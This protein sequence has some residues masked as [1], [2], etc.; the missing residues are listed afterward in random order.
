MRA[1]GID[2]GT[3]NSVVAV[4]ENDVPRIVPN[5]ENLPLT[6]SVVSCLKKS[7]EIVV[8]RPAQNNAGRDPENTI[9]S[10]KRLMGRQ[11]GEQRVEEVQ[12]RYGFHLAPAPAPDADDQGVR[13]MLNGK[14]HTPVEVSAMILRQL[15]SD[16]EVA[17]GEP[18]THA[19]ITVPAYFEERQRSA[20]VEAGKLAGLTVLEI[21]DEPTAAALAFG[22]GKEDERHRVLV[23]DLGGGTFDISLI[24]MFKNN[25]AVLEI[26]GDNWLG[27]DDFDQMIIKRMI[28]WA[29]AEFGFEPSKHQGFLTKAKPEAETAKKAL[30]M[31][32]RAQILMPINAPDLGMIDIDIELT[33][34]ELESDMENLLQRTIDLVRKA[35]ANQSLRPDDVSRVLLVGGST[36]IP[37]VHRLL[38]EQFGQEKV[39]KDVSP[40]ECVALGAAVRASRYKLETNE[41]K[42]DGK[43]VIH[44][45][46]PMHLGIQ[47]VQG[48]DTDVFVPII[49]KGTHYPLDKPRTRIFY[50]TDPKQKMIKVP[51]YEGESKQ[52]SLN[53]QQRV[54]EFPL[55]EEMGANQ[56]IEVSFGYNRNRE[57]T[58][59]VRL[60]GTDTFFEQHLPPNKGRR[61]AP[62]PKAADG[63]AV[64]WQE[65]LSP[66]IRRAKTFLSGYSKYMSKEDHDQMAAA[67]TAAEVA[68]KANDEH[69][70]KR[71]GMEVERKM[72][73]S[74]LASLIYFAEHTL[75]R[76]KPED[77]KVMA[78]ALGE[79]RRAVDT[80][81]AAQV[82]QLAAQ[83]HEGLNQILAGKDKG[84]IEVKARTSGGLLGTQ[85][86]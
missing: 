32:Q 9:F 84:T 40:M 54:L 26:Q 48:D 56:A 25:Y 13:V 3:T 6:P 15:K 70:G 57:I 21:I 42:S 31:Q 79:L 1:I 66:L 19:V 24:Q 58:V 81:Q 16:A 60:V 34:A 12:R 8:G 74:G 7:G 33:R 55:K 50:P 35:L 68:L 61:A 39:R 4:V 28:D 43:G 10:I 80:G 76:A 45:V 44:Q 75:T 30:S 5:G 77:A 18:V 78:Q 29:R 47:A 86:S 23:Y 2:L 83:V 46:T 49:E 72:G 38:T 63:P 27:G 11:Y 59:G 85:K 69:E 65:E 14:P 41:I 53:E 22:L 62:R 71:A 52:A 36:A 51:I 73:G 17:L 82:Q 37:M 20:T 64:I 67:I